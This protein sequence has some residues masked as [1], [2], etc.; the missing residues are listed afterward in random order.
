MALGAVDS[1][2]W[3]TRREDWRAVGRVEGDPGRCYDERRDHE[4]CGQPTQR[5]Q[6]GGAL[7]AEQPVHQGGD[8]REEHTACH[9][10]DH[11]RR[12]GGAS[13]PAS[14]RMGGR[15]GGTQVRGRT[16]AEE[17]QEQDQAQRLPIPA[18]AGIGRGQHQRHERAEAASTDEEDAVDPP[19]GKIKQTT[20][21]ET[22]RRRDAEDRWISD[23][24]DAKTKEDQCQTR[25]DKDRDAYSVHVPL[26][27]SYECRPAGAALA[28]LPRLPLRQEQ[29][30][31]LPP[32]HGE[33]GSPRSTPMS[34]GAA[35]G[36]RTRHDDLQ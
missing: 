35:G 4:D 13:A 32:V 21:A 9:D 14:R 23:H 25:R 11:Q 12:V 15:Y 7:V 34:R 2:V 5:G 19:R 29:V 1:H 18:T 6:A 28:G 3:R 36:G 31:S 17:E 22:R 33:R 16:V 8:G 30:V 27:T 24:Q 26:Q 10:D 20:A